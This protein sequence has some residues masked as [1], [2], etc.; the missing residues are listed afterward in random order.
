MSPKTVA[1]PAAKNWPVL[2][3]FMLALTTAGCFRPLYGEATHP[4]LVE[5]MRAIAVGQVQSTG[6]YSQEDLDRV[7]H[8]LGNDLIANL[9]GTGSTPP[10]KYRLNVTISL[11]T[12]TP[13]VT[14]QIGLANSTTMVVNADYVLTPAGGGTE[15]VRGAASEATNSDITLNRF[16]NLRSMRDDEIRLS[17]YLAD[18]IE[19]RVAAFL[20]V[21]K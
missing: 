4:G 17:K 12:T 6:S 20:G 2:M 7:A 8:Y 11:S 18:E 5:D 9:N 10:P 19:L 14:S 1:L 15:V 16:S 21:K 3:T 13:T